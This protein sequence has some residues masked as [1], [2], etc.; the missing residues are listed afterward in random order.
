MDFKAS[1]GSWIYAY[2]SSGGP[3]NADDQ[4]A[5]IKQ[6]N[7]Q[8]AFSWDFAN[9]KGGSSVNPLVNA[10]PAASGSASGSG[11]VAATSCIQRS[12]ASTA[13]S[14]TSATS[15]LATSRAAAGPTQSIGNPV[16]NS[17]PVDWRTMR[18][19]EF[20]SLPTGRPTS[21]PFDPRDDREY[22]GT[23]H[24]VLADRV[25]AYVPKRQALPYCDELTG[26]DNTNSNSNSNSNTNA[27]FTPL[28]ASQGGPN[29]QA[30][31]IAHGVLAS[32]AFVLLFPAGAIAIRLAT[33]PGVVW[34]HAAFQICAYLV[35]IAAFG[36]GVY[37]ATKM[38]LLNAYHP[39]IGIVV[40]VALFFQPILGFMHHLMFKK[41]QHRTLWSYAHIWLGRIAVTLGIINGGLGL[42]LANSMHMSS[43]K[44]IVAYGVVAGFMWLAWVAASVIGERRRKV[45]G[46]STPPKYRVDRHG[47]GESAGGSES[48][49]A[50]PVEGHFAPKER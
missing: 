15:N 46:K 39:I 44:G 19:S 24:R 11:G 18:P 41:Y 25:T 50:V 12:A 42:K 21:R 4:S 33:F 34:L 16:S 38:K 28:N 37:M 1:T 45:A 23:I 20:G 29:R 9:A 22:L 5:S 17:A 49:A 7:N 35:Y 27:G 8:A 13:G 36:L 30:M 6:H 48:E 32:L 40:L 47:S 2:Q 14:A 31:L 10:A 43:Q 3:K 26:G